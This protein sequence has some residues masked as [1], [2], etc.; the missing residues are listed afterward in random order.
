[1]KKLSTNMADHGCI[2]GR[3]GDLYF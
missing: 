3:R 2:C 1:V